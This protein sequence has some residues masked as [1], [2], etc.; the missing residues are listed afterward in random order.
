VSTNR[1]EMVKRAARGGKERLPG[2]APSPQTRPSLSPSSATMEDGRQQQQIAR[3]GQRER[4]R[5][6]IRTIYDRLQKVLSPVLVCVNVEPLLFYTKLL[7]VVAGE[8]H[9][10]NVSFWLL[11][12]LSNAFCRQEVL[13]SSFA[14][15][16]NTA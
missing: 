11:Q 6:E 15:I 2:Q 9:K 10:Q 14:V 5:K 8:E 7:W 13:E 16:F 3:T 4:A 12:V 1:G